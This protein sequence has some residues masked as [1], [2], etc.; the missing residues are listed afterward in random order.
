MREHAGDGRP[1]EG[2]AAYL[3][4]LTGHPNHDVARRQMHT[5]GGM[6]CVRLRGGSDAAQ[7]LLARARLFSLAESFGGVESLIGQPATMTYASI[8]AEVRA[9]RGVDDGLV[10]LGVGIE[11]HDDLRDDLRDAPS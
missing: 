10:R 9:A 4:G 2:R 3:S 8:P 1:P 11:D 6:I 7:R 5:F